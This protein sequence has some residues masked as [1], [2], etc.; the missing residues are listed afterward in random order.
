MSVRANIIQCDGKQPNIINDRIMLDLIF[1]S[2]RHETDM[3]GIK[4]IDSWVE[5]IHLLTCL[6][7]FSTCCAFSHFILWSKTLTSL[8]CA[9]GKSSQ[10]ST[11][12]TRSVPV[13]LL[14]IMEGASVNCTCGV[15]PRFK[16]YTGD[17]SATYK[18]WHDWLDSGRCTKCNKVVF[19]CYLLP[20]WYQLS[21]LGWSPPWVQN[22]RIV[23][24]LILWH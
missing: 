14:A 12:S 8:E 21:S 10:I 17:G 4:M 2:Y 3:V 24:S 6:V 22:R 19:P 15:A 18:Q 1:A 13:C 23:L 5:N 11:T 20:E 16:A 9:L 7:W